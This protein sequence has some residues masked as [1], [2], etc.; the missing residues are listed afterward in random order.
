MVFPLFRRFNSPSRFVYL[1]LALGLATVTVGG[2]LL[3]LRLQA[4]AGSDSTASA[5]VPG[6][7]AGPN[8]IGVGLVPDT[9]GLTDMAFNWL[10]YQGLL[11]AESELGVT[12]T[13]YTPTND[14]EY[15]PN[16]QKCVDDGNA[17]CI[18]VGYPTAE[19][20]QVAATANPT[21]AFGLVDVEVPSYPNNLRSMLFSADQSGYLA[22]TLA[23][24][25][26]QSSVVGAVAGMEIPP[27]TVFTDPYRQGALC[28]K[29][30][31]T[32][33]VTYTNNFGDAN[34][35]AQAAQAL[36]AQGADV[37]FGVGGNMGNGAV[38]TAT[39]SGAWGIGVDVDVY[40]SL[41]MSG[42]VP[43]SD[44]VL[45][46]AMKRLD[47]AVYDTIADVISGT[48]S[49]GPITYDL[50]QG[51]AGLAPYHEADPEV[52][53]SVRGA[54][55]R[56][57]RGLIDGVINPNGPCPSYQFLPDVVRNHSLSAT[58]AP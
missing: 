11:R 17:L 52:P 29:P 56:V 42:T 57:E 36:M 34:V 14:S 55:A 2:V 46:S 39:Q 53:D 40:H 13:V 49:S 41:F 44:K 48:F 7:P 5:F 26:S 33:I 20:I 50:A 23:G 8:T 3:G 30:E 1:L 16:L 27:V 9:A 21:V 28:S 10:S 19:A 24:L 15:G 18:S 25:M 54:L 6:A 51:G 58:P 32:V 38:L 12:G 47:N 45:S 4:S 35:G 43:G 37:I 31:T 22:G